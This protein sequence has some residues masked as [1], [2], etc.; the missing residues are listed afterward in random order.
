MEK[1]YVIAITETWATA[2]YLMTEYLVP[3]YLSFFKN[4]LHKKGG[5]VMSYV[6]NT[7]PTMKVKKKKKQDGKKTVYIDLET[8]KRNKL[9]IGTLYR[10][11]KQHAAYDVA[12][13]E[14][15]H[16][17]TQNK[18]SVIIGVFNSPKINWST[19]KGDQEGN[20]P[21]E[22]LKDTFMNQ[23]IT[24]PTGENNILDLV[25]VID[26]DLVCDGRVGEKLTGC[27]HPLIRFNIRTEHEL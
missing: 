24:Q 23:T 9:A 2:D 6:K 12:L 8:S 22:M 13:Y 14:E 27:D 1:P 18:Q 4:R 20:R 25:L 17:M 11:P 16:A 7:I 19:M 26:P 5:G 10:P 15:I 3:G 21:L